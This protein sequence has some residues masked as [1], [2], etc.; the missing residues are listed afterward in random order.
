MGGQTY[1]DSFKA[2]GEAALNKLKALLHEGNVK[3]IVIEH[4]GRTVAEFPLTA[5]IVGAALAPIPAAI[6]ALIGFLDNCTIHVERETQQPEETK[7][8]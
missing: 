6:G 8:A 1:R 5:G 2:E 4:Q 7:R 3:R